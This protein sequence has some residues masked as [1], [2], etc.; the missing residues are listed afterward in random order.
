[1]APLILSNSPDVEGV[2]HQTTPREVFTFDKHVFVAWRSGPEPV[3]FL[4]AV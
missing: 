4:E 2:H 1:M 3:E